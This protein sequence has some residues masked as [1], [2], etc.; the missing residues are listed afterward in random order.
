MTNEHDA[1]E[2]YC[3]Y[4]SCSYSAPTETQVRSHITLA[5]H[6]DHEGEDGY[7]LGVQVV[8][9]DGNRHGYEGKNKVSLPDVT[10]SD[11][12]D[13]VKGGK[14]LILKIAY[15]NPEQ[16][17]TDIHEQAEQEQIDYSY[18]RVRD[19]I[20]EHI[21]TASDETNDTAEP[22]QESDSDATDTDPEPFLFGSSVTA[23]D[24][25][26]AGPTVDPRRTTADAAEQT[27]AESDSTPPEPDSASAADDQAPA[28]PADS[29]HTELHYDTGSIPDYW[30][31]KQQ[32]AHPDQS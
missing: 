3:P 26:T 27:D 20:K 15:N 11:I 1:G 16:S 10:L 24:P 28:Q 8:D 25:F 18:G 7:T 21:E 31:D 30:T 22:D 13:D 5:E 23:T 19:I 6:G 12:T 9:S 32:N 2:Y 29:D 4:D 14:Q 17:Y